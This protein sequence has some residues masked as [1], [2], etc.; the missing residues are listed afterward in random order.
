MA[1]VTAAD[2]AGD[3]VAEM[4]EEQE[5]ITPAPSS[6]SDTATANDRLDLVS[7]QPEPTQ[8]AESSRAKQF[9]DKTTLSGW[10]PQTLDDEKYARKGDEIPQKSDHYHRRRS[11]SNADTRSK[12]HRAPVQV[13]ESC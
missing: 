7:I 1:E 12:R 4:P 6:T 9:A 8:R 3:M 11:Q 13:V 10:F 2:M 5:D